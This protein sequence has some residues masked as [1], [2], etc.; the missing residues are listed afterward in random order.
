M[1]RQSQGI[2][3]VEIAFGIIDGFILA[4]RPLGLGEAA[5]L[6]GMPKSK[7]HKYLVSFVRLGIL[8]QGPE[9]SRYSLGPK[10]LETGLGILRSLDM[11]SVCEPELYDLRNQSGQA[12]ALALWLPEGP[13]I[14]RYLRSFRP[15]SIDMQVGF[16]APVTASAAGMCFAAYLPEQAYRHLVRAETG[17]ETLDQSFRAMLGKIREQ[18]FACRE[19][20]NARIPG[21]KALACPVFG[22]AGEIAASLILIG[23]E[24]SN[25][26]FPD[27]RTVSLLKQ[28]SQRVS[29][30]LGHKV[31][32]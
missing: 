4:G 15:V 14:V 16:Y 13:M 30:T 21:S 11:L 5:G 27:S 26:D 24:D 7:L 1:P 9:S 19:T 2:Q 3:S 22:G 12:A 20:P 18:G 8:R 29:V 10:L 25:A 23:F 17:Q 32:P 6:L 28:A 31:L